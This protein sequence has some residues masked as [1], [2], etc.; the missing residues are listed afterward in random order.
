MTDRLSCFHC[1]EP[2]PKGTDLQVEIDGAAR[3]MCCM[4]CQSIAKA[5]VDAGAQAYYRQRSSTALDVKKLEAL[6]PWASLLSDPQWASQHVQLTNEQHAAQ[7]TLAIEGLRCGACSWLIEKIL[8]QTPGVLAA[9]ANATTERLFVKWNPGLVSLTALAQRV[10]RIGYAVLPIGSAPIEAARK[11]S[12]RQALRRLFVAGLSSAQ[13]MMY[14]YPEY[15]EGGGLDDDIRSL[16]RTASMLI[17]VPVM[18]YSA[19][20][21]F[22]S[23]WRALTQRRLNMDVPVSLGLWIAFLASL[24]AWW[25]NRGEVYFD[26]VSMFVFLLLGT[27]WIESRIRAKTS[28]Q[29]DRLAT[30]LPTLASRI[31]PNPGTT[32]AWNLREGDRVRVA[33]GDRIPADGLLQSAATDLDNAS[34][35]GESLPVPVRHGERVTEGAINLGPAIEVFIDTSVTQG[36]L[37]RLSQLAEQ[38]AADRPQWVTWA[39]RIGAQFTAGILFLTLAL[40]AVSVGL[41]LPTEQWLASVIAVLVVTCPCAL[42]MAGPAAYAAALARLL[43]QG[44]AISRAHALE[45]LAA[46]T[47]VV[48]DKTGTLTDPSR[49]AVTMHAIPHTP[50][51]NTD[52]GADASDSGLW[53]ITA[54]LA[55]PSTH[56]LARAIARQA[57]TLLGP[58]ALPVVDHLTQH[59]GLGL[60]GWMQG[61]R[62]RLG[63]LSFIQPSAEDR[64]RAQAHPDC[65]VFLSIDSVLRAGFAIADEPRPESAALIARLRQEGKTVWCLSGDRADR[66]ADL[67]QRVGLASDQ[68]RAELTPEQ[69]RQ[70]VAQLQQSGKVVAMVGDGHNDA[71]VIAQADVSIAVQGAAPIAQQ[72]ADI[73]SMRPGLHS[74]RESLFLAAHARRVLRQNLS[75]ALAYNVVAVPFAAAG[76]ISPLLASVGMAS[77]SL[78]VVLNSARLLRLRFSPT[79]AAP[80]PA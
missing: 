20:P 42:S 9:R 70:W 78:L 58:A 33:S 80:S 68:V 77:S 39:D 26:S 49:S 65:T 44:I 50:Q 41:K 76:L 16:M 29:R 54:A 57:Q 28:A 43:E 79:R 11:A 7:T 25:S 73:Y 27:R 59:A 62:V 37:S 32:A 2:V 40:I 51:T 55:T 47:D 60:E 30:T 19:T 64:M 34:L 66:V 13:V 15:L 71:P 21:F 61:Q 31:S 56:P 72:K 17:T 14:A 38:A 67:A 18:L 63:S 23:A 48:F 75:W 24:W 45:R 10:G 52:A 69:K 35:T 12:A 1:G 3:A 46:V 74:V 22:E 8:Q 6:A 5:I 36:T 53:A 4:G